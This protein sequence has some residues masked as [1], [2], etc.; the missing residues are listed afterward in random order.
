ML[1]DVLRAVE[2][3]DILMDDL[4][5]QGATLWE[6]II[7]T[8]NKHTLV[9][10]DYWD[11]SRFCLVTTAFPLRTNGSRVFLMQMRPT[12]H[13]SAVRINGKHAFRVQERVS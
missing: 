7:G 3:Q 4:L 9:R 1:S 12:T 8:V 11:D 10:M 5:Q 13:M 6:D 2:K